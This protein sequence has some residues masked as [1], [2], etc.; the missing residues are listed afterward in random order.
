MEREKSFANHTMTLDNS[1]NWGDSAAGVY[2]PNWYAASTNSNH[3]KQVAARLEARAVQY[4][5]PLY[6]SLRKWK[7]RRVFLDMPL[8]P[9]YI[10]VRLTRTSQLRALEIPGVVR[11]IGFGGQPCALPENE[12]EILRTGIANRLNIEPHPCVTAG[13]RVRVMKGP[14]IGLEGI[15]V[16]QKNSS[17][18]VL[19]L[20]A[21]ARSAAVEVDARDVDPIS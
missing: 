7:D 14:L 19:T 10:F 1:A 9:G 8:F 13:C 17:R 4:F 3:E 5:L 11:L 15:L 21:I 12:I 2:Q 6:K 20:D 16:R 18:V